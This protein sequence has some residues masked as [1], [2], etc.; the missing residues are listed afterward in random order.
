MAVIQLGYYQREYLCEVLSN[1]RVIEYCAN[2][3]YLSK[4]LVGVRYDIVKRHSLTQAQI[5]QIKKLSD[6]TGLTW[7]LL[8]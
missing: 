6:I 4:F 5:Y 1:S 3:D 2:N 8:F 7:R